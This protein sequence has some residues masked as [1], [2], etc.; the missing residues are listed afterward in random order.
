MALLVSLLAA[1]ANSQS[2]EGS[3]VEAK[4]LHQRIDE[5]VDAARIGPAASPASDAEFLRRAYLDL[6]GTIPTSAEARAF[7]DDTSADKRQKL[8]ERLLATPQHARHLATW[9]DVM[10]MERRGAKGVAD[11]E[12]RKYLFDAAR[13]NKPY[14]QLVREILTAD[15]SDA[16]TRPAA[17]FLLARDAEPNIITRDVGRIIFGRDMQ[18]C[19][20]HDHPLVDDYYQAEYYGIYALVGRT[21][22]W[23]DKKDK[24]KQY[25]TE[26]ADGDPTFVSVFDKAKIERTGRPSVP[27]GEAIVDP[28]IPAG[29]EYTVKPD[30]EV[31]GVPKYSRRDALA[32][33]ATQNNPAFERNI[34]NRVWAMLFG[35]GLVNPVDMHH[36]ANPPS[37]EPVLDLLANEFAAHKYDLRWLIGELGQTQTYQRS[38]DL[39]TELATAAAQLS[40]QI[41]ADEAEREKL[42]A[43]AVASKEAVTKIEDQVDTAKDAVIAANAELAPPQAAA[44]AAKKPADEAAAALAAAEKDFVAKREAAGPLAE[45]AAKAAEAAAKLADQKDVVDA[46]AALTAANERQTAIVAAAQKTVDDRQAVAKT[47]ADTLAA[48]N[49]AVAAASAKVAEATKRVDELFAGFRDATAKWQLDDAT[50]DRVARRAADANLLVDYVQSDNQI[51]AAQADITK[52]AAELTAAN[53]KAAVSA[54]Q[55]TA[56]ASTVAEAEKSTAAAKAAESEITQQIAGLQTTATALAEAF[57]KTDAARQLLPNDAELADATA[58]LKSRADQSAAAV[59]AEQPKLVATTA[60]TKSAMD[61]QA[62]ATAAMLAAQ[63]EAE[64]LK[65]LAAEASQRAADAAAK[66]EAAQQ[67]QAELERDLAARL[68]RR[69]ALGNVRAL[70]PEQL[71]WS[72]MQASGL[73]ENQRAAAIAEWDKANPATDE[74]AA[75][76]PE[77]IAA[78]EIAVEQTTFDKLAGNVGPFI[79]LF[80]AAAGQPQDDFYA[81]A[82]QALF[83]AN[84]GNVRGWLAPGGENLTAR[85]A[86]LTEPQPLAEELY[87]SL[88]TRKPTDAEVAAVESYLATRPNDRP[89]ALQEIA[90]S[91][92]ASAEF[93][94]NH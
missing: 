29:E 30:K 19:Q 31:R 74:A 63:K 72:M 20:C 88:L 15:G 59:A 47:T 23:V 79:P 65:Q 52:L 58:K 53:E 60:A 46:A 40:G 34:V 73:A 62:A 80:A 3:P 11:A 78:R 57:A 49:A 67:S 76:A 90:W 12:W 13:A 94:F 71:A 8:I 5:L 93:R 75:S 64:S 66:R 28:Q 1:A 83:F 89:A 68:T 50:A 81:T 56:M 48:A 77:R 61:Q 44:A 6:V 41:A 69:L 55:A 91:L 86:R 24:D 36:R 42:L 7:L 92:L 82:D 26:K 85:L 38:I 10:L 27:L 22:V 9:L 54:A 35:Q 14:D 16:A 51:A 45:A 2:S 32:Q 37:S 84:G 18:C 4:P 70:S 39:P 25:L 33:A 87:L 21:S 43:V 17:N